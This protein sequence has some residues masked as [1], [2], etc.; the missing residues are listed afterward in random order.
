MLENT[1]VE[2]LNYNSS[3]VV[4]IIQRAYRVSR[5]SNTSKI[6]FYKTNKSKHITYKEIINNATA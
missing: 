2:A 1:F 3:N 6:E 5:F 4:E